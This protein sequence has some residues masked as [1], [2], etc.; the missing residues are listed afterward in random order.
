MASPAVEARSNEAGEFGCSRSPHNPAPPGSRGHSP[1][2]RV[3]VARVCTRPRWLQRRPN[4]LPL[5]GGGPYHR[6]ARGGFPASSGTSS[7]AEGRALH[8]RS[9]GGLRAESRRRETGTS[10]VVFC[11]PTV[12]RG[13]GQSWSLGSSEVRLPRRPRVPGCPSGSARA[14]ALGGGGGAE[15]AAAGSRASARL[16]RLLGSVADGS[17]RC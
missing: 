17:G 3:R 7:G 4:A 1:S 6:S 10:P 9:A 2:T 14:E 15:D 8:T 12:P 5:K 11:D 13:G 16:G